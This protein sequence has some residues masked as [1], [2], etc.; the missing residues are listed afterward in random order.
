MVCDDVV[1]TTTATTVAPP[2]GLPHQE[3]EVSG[4]Q[5]NTVHIK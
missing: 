1:A 2:K 4:M 5:Y 3:M